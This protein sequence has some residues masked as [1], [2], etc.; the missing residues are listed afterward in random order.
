MNINSRTHFLLRLPPHET[1][2]NHAP[3]LYMG[4]RIYATNSTT[5]AHK[6]WYVTSQ[7]TP[8]YQAPV[9][10]TQKRVTTVVLH[11]SSTQT[12]RRVDDDDGGVVTTTATHEQAK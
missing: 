4:K 6:Q 12:T 1:P 10:H 8:T 3:P 9:N 7:N 2:I 5:A 11:V